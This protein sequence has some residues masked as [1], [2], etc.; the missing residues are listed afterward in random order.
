MFV[1]VREP[2]GKRRNVVKRGDVVGIRAMPGSTPLSRVG[3]GGEATI[4]SITRDGH[5]KKQVT[6]QYT[7]TTDKQ[8]RVVTLP[9]S[10]L[11]GGDTSLTIGDRVVVSEVQPGVCVPEGTEGTLLGGRGDNYTVAFVMTTTGEGV[12]LENPVTVTQD[13]VPRECLTFTGEAPDDDG[14]SSDEEQDGDEAEADTESDYDEG[15]VIWRLRT[16]M[17][18]DVLDQMIQTLG[19]D[20]IETVAECMEEGTFYD[21]L[22]AVLKLC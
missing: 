16:Q 7:D 1:R 2:R 18:P 6:V 15:C 12:A 8:P 21:S 10:S 9:P 3:S 4:K 11:H 17:A 22:D 14:E 13:H 19:L 5:G 20:E